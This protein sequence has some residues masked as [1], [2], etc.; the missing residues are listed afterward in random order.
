MFRNKNWQVAIYAIVFGVLNSFV[1][2]GVLPEWVVYISILL[3]VCAIVW[4]DIEYALYT[5]LLS[6]PFYI[7]IPNPVFDSFSGWRIAFTALFIKLLF[8]QSG[9]KIFN[10]PSLLSRIKSLELASWDRF[11]KW[12]LIVMLISLLVA[13]YQMIGVKKIAFVVNIYLLY[14]VVINAVKSIEQIKRTSVAV[15]LSLGVVLGIGFVQLAA[16]I[17]APMYYFWQYWA[18]FISKAYYGLTLADSLTYSNSWFAFYPNQPPSLRMFS[19]LPDSHSFGVLAMF[20]IPYASALILFVQKRTTKIVL[21]LIILFAVVGI[22]LSGTRG[23]WVASLAPLGLLMLLIFRKYGR[24]LAIKII[25]PILLFFL[26]L[27]CSPLIQK[28]VNALEG[29]NAVGNSVSRAASI[30][31]LDESSNAGRLDIWKD[32]AEYISENPILGSGFGNFVSS[33]E[34]GEADT[35]EEVANE[36]EEAFNLPKRYVTGHSLYLDI[37]AEL[38]IIGFIFF[39][40]YIKSILFSIVGFFQKHTLYSNESWVLFVV[41]QG[42]YLIWFLAYSVFDGALFN[43]RVLIYFLINIGLTYAV[44]RLYRNKSAVI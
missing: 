5:V 23:I 19:V 2:I 40:L 20:L 38:G 31:D 13:E 4:F 10:I 30:Y 32:T 15:L 6:M 35:F 7:V 21:A 18:M 22:V 11:A 16:Y 17:V 3:N 41:S 12:L 37:L 24:A 36:K 42:M 43:D 1:A 34:D 28:A 14:V 9:T 27:L 25:A 29:T 44:M 26:V 8:Q 39:V 33:L